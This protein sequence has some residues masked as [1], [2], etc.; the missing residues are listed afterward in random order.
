MTAAMIE[1]HEVANQVHP[2]EGYDAYGA[3]PWLRAA[4]ARS[5]PDCR[6]YTYL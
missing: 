3:D 2:L 6:L 4:V 5:L 1:T